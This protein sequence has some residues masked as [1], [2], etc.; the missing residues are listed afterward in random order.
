DDDLA[1]P[2]AWA[3]DAAGPGQSPIVE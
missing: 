3:F 2:R 1:D